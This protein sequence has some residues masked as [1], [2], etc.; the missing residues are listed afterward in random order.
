MSTDPW[1]EV[2]DRVF[3]R[4]HD[5]LALNVGVVVGG[6][7]VLVFD[8]RESPPRGRELRAAIGRLT[9]LPVRWVV[10]SH[11]H[12]DHTFGN[13]AF[14]DAALWGHPSTASFLEHDLGEAFESALRWLPDMAPELEGLEVAAPDNLVDPSA[15]IDIG[16]R[17]VRL[18]YLGRGHTDSDLVMQVSDTRVLFVGDLFEASGPPQFGDA[19]PVEWAATAASI[20]ALAS[21]GAVAGHGPFMSPADVSAQADDLAAVAD[22]CRAA[23][24]DGRGPEDAV[25]GPFPAATMRT[26]VARGIRELG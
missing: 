9:T 3:Y 7:G 13:A 11:F 5:S 26:A 2:A 10:N 19:Y 15:T 21:D 1:H 25:V 16:G 23:R 17:T 20:A 18:D 4:S 22:A 6:D 24:D 8:S 12:W 14:G